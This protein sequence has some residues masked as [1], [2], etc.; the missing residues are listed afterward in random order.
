MIFHDTSE[1]EPGD[2]STEHHGRVVEDKLTF[3]A[4]FQLASVLSQLPGV[5]PA[6]GRQPQVDALVVGQVLR[7]VRLRVGC[8]IGGRSDHRHAQIRPDAQR[9]H[10]LGDLL[11]EANAGIE[12]FGDDVGQAGIDRQFDMDVRVA[13]QERLQNGPE[14]AVG[15]VLGGG[16]ADRACRLLTQRA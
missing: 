16:D 7:R 10:I 3:H 8:K 2:G 5:D 1:A 15:G 12:P 9:D 6:G 13:G 11:A 14:D 4:D